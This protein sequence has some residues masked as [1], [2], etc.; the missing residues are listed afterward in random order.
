MLLNKAATGRQA[1]TNTAT[2]AANVIIIHHLTTISEGFGTAEWV[3][4][5]GG[6]ESV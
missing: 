1:N 3:I 6:T 4:D 2:S 5:P